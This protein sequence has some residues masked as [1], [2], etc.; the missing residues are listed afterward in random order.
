MSTITRGIKPRGDLIG[1]PLVLHE[2]VVVGGSNGLLVQTH[3]ICVSSFETGDLSRHQGVLVSEGRWIVFSP[4]A[5]LFPVLCREV[6]P[7]ALLVGRRL[8][9]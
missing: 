7:S 2:T 1:Q 4:L 8:L 5:Q 9:A 6:A 3:R